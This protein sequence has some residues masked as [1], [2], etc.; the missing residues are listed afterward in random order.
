[1]EVD[2][3]GDTLLRTLQ[4]QGLPEVITAVSPHALVEPKSVPGILKS[5]LSFIQYF[6]P[7][8][9]RVFNL[10]SAADRLNAVRS[11]SEGKPADIR[12]REG[13]SWIL[14]EAAEWE[15][16]ILKVTGVVRGSSL[17][18][19]R[20]VHLPNF[21]DYQISQVR[22]FILFCHIKFITSGI[23]LDYFCTPSETNEIRP[24]GRHGNSAYSPCGA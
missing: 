16:D 11:L 10:Q 2:A 22:F 5:L 7:S 12:W 3:W 17:S 13:R 23:L 19:N 18:A 20:L 1:M 15:D 21:G 4:A 9:T 8:Q 24:Y 6:V 14:G